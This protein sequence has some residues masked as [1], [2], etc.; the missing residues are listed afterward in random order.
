M[1]PIELIVAPRKRSA[2]PTVT[3]AVQAAL[4]R[5]GRPCWIRIEP[6]VY[7]ESVT[8]SGE[9]TLFAEEGPGSVQ[10]VAL[11]TAN[12]I[13]SYSLLTLSGLGLF[14]STASALVIEAGTVQAKQCHLESQAGA[15]LTMSAVARG[16]SRLI[17]SS[18]SV[19]GGGVLG[20]H[21]QLTIAD[22]SITQTRA[23]AVAQSESGVLDLSDTA[24][25]RPGIHGVRVSGN[26]SATIRNCSVQD[27]GNSSI[28][29][30]DGGRGLV[31]DCQIV[32]SPQIGVHFLT[33]ASGSV[34][35]CSISGVLSGVQVRDHSAGLVRDCA[36]TNFRDSAVYVDGESELTVAGST[37]SDGPAGAGVL[38]S[39]AEL[40]N[41]IISSVDQYGVLLGG[42]VQFSMAD[43]TIS[44]CDYA[45]IA[46]D[47]ETSGAAAL[48]TVGMTGARRA[49]VEARGILH[50]SAVDCT[51]RDSIGSG[52]EASGRA[53]LTLTRCHAEGTR[54]GVAVRDLAVVTAQEV[55][56]KDS[57]G[58]GITADE[59]AVVQFS[60]GTVSGSARH[61]IRISRGVTGQVTGTAFSGNA[62]GDVLNEAEVSVASVG[63]A[64][65]QAPAG[66]QSG[67][68]ALEQ[69]NALIGLA[70]VKE[71]IRA[72]LNLV[73][74]A[75]QRRKAGLAVVSGSRH[76]VFSGPP[77]TGKTMVA[78]LYAAI[79]AEAEVLPSALLVEVS[80]SNLVGNHIG[81][82]AI[83]TRDTFLK[84]CGGVLFIDEAYTLSRS[85]RGGSGPDFG[86]EAIDELVKL[87]EDHRD[88]VV[89]IVAGYEAEM[90]T[91]LKANPG[92]ESRFARTIDFPPYGP[93]ELTEIVLSLVRDHDYTLDAPAKTAVLDH[94]TAAARSGTPSGRDARTLF[95]AM[96]ERQSE[97]LAQ[98][99]MPT[100]TQLTALTGED[101]PHLTSGGRAPDP[102]LT[103][104]LLNELD[105]MPSL[106]EVKNEIRTL[107]DRIKVNQQRTAVGLMSRLEPEHLV[108]AGPP[109]TGKTTVA[110]L[111]GRLLAS[112]GVLPGTSFV[113]ATRADLVAGYIGQ[114]A[115]RTT[116]MFE[117]ARGGVLFI[118]EAYTLAPVPSGTFRD[119]G[120]EAIETLL[121]LMEDH[122]SE[123]A[124]IV[125]GYSTEMARFLAAN[126][127]LQSRFART[128]YFP[129]YSDE[130]LGLLFEKAAAKSSYTCADGVVDAAGQA[131]GAHRND[132]NFG[133]GRTARSLAEQS[134][135]AH[136]RR[137]AGSATQIS[138]EDL[139]A[140]TL[141][142]L[143]AALAMFSF[144]QP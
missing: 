25:A 89:V 135:A 73:R 55:T 50:V 122:R 16:M 23:N 21:A 96:I 26:C 3:A 15:E 142:D 131:L 143:R 83:K 105:A 38:N 108:F 6:G 1:R 70:P 60:G 140:L 52:F 82:T 71:Q 141:S 63:A 101:M 8:L 53:R 93:E 19:T 69:L 124:V 126:P 87:M 75:E 134:I 61:G 121:K 29:F 2:Y 118:D 10:I 58:D 56:V 113:E 5:Q 132:E 84:A 36:I 11:G 45:L 9:L 88:D 81:E 125:A 99:A 136:A 40:R 12:T 139:S 32:R 39:R 67:A 133:N 97:R 44:D 31:A 80:R 114:T 57:A 4:S 110:R 41:V 127:G 14:S 74:T 35:R 34:E 51:A 103:N 78:R 137:I 130:V 85:N 68:S 46:R 27:A 92:L 62:H 112:L 86:Q 54:T 104:D 66:A 117:Q 37:L 42:S 43:S 47:D 48:T 72:Q 106:D 22:C 64:P 59:Q 30:D 77:G 33:R 116:E 7:H 94:F 95:E 28:C 111:Y 79:L 102:T 100:T 49:A 13:T 76:L 107:I 119:F 120:Q 123:I 144:Y 128:I 24:I 91:F 17:M 20:E 90:R 65:Q 115:A 138:A 109:G 129:S 18:C 98:I